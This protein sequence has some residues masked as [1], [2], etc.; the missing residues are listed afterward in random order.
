MSI[1]STNL[2]FILLEIIDE[3]NT[4]GLNLMLTNITVYPRKLESNKHKKFELQLRGIENK[5]QLKKELNKVLN[6]YIDIEKTKDNYLDFWSDN[7]QIGEFKIDSYFENVT[8][9]EKEDWIESYQRLLN[10]Y[11]KQS[12]QTT[13]ES[14]LLTKFLE[15]L[16]NL[17]QDELKKHKRK[18][19]FFKNDKDKIK[20]LTDRMNLANRI[21][22]MQE[23]FKSELKSIE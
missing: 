12:D 14:L 6:D 7:Y 3:Q 10:F 17:T 2:N 18:I 5:K 22:K 16:E 20:S 13:K 23:Q 9:L 11:Y 4:D 1:V 19:E 8:E 21:E 15:R